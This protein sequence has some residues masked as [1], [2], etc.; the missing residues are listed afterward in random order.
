M[1]LCVR[2]SDDNVFALNVLTELNILRDTIPS[3]VIGLPNWE[4]FDNMDNE[5][6]KNLNLHYFSSSYVNYADNNG[7]SFHPLASRVFFD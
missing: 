4:N 1:I 3:T 6:F 2:N 5:I 7:C